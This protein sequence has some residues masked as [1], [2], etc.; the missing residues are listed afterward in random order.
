MAKAVLILE[1]GTVVPGHG[2]GIEGEVF[3]EIVFNTSM[4]GY[5]E[6]FT[7]PSYAGQILILTYPLIGNYG[8]HLK[9]CESSSVKI[10]GLVIK[11]PAFFSTRGE[12][13]NKYLVRNRIPG[14]WGID[15]RALTLKIRYHGTMKALLVHTS[16]NL[17]IQ[18]LIKKVRSL[19]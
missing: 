2:F 17:N 7:D 14:I 10:R 16:K 18:R 15:T 13:I 12:R 4:T 6:A 19:P 3:G 9:L 8:F 1:D 11:E 5:Q